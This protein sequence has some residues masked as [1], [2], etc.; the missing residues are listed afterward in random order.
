MYIPHKS[1]ADYVEMSLG[2]QD[3]SV[4]G[5]NS[6]SLEMCWSA[7]NPS[8]QA[9][10]RREKAAKDEREGKVKDPRTSSVSRAA[11]LI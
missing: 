7:P 10:E 6:Q 4:P 11:F 3:R 8:F 5:C 1:V 2:T 9:L